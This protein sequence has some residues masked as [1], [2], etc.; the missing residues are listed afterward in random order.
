[1]IL[2]M[3]ASYGAVR[4]EYQVVKHSPKLGELLSER[5]IALQ[6]VQ[7]DGDA[8]TLPTDEQ[9]IIL[10]TVGFVQRLGD[11]WEGFVK[12]CCS[13]GHLVFLGNDVTILPSG[14]IESGS[15]EEHFARFLDSLPR[16]V[17]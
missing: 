2:K 7:W 16:S 9:V 4:G 14:E 6:L 10:V 15:S 12:W 17:H 5:D 8:S 11:K 1:M 13:V 3:F